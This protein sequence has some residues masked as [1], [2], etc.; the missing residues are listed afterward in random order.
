MTDEIAAFL[1]SPYPGSRDR[2]RVGIG[3]Y[4][5][6]CETLHWG[7]RGEK[8]MVYVKRSDLNRELDFELVIEEER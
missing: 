6:P 2:S 5:I 3:C 8:P 4:W 1:A 7:E